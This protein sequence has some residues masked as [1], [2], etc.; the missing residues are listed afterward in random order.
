[1]KKNSIQNAHAGCISCIGHWL[2]TAVLLL[3]VILPSQLY[4]Q[5]VKGHTPKGQTFKGQTFKVT[6]IVKDSK[7]SPIEG[8]S[9]LVKGT[10]FGSTT[11]QQG[12][13]SIEAPSPKS[14]LEFTN[15]GYTPW[16]EDIN[17]RN[18]IA[19]TLTDKTSDMS[20]VVV[21]GYGTQRKRDITGAIS[22][23][24][25][26]QIAERQ[27]VTVA[28]ALQGQ[29][30][31]LQ[32]AVGSG[33]PGAS[34]ISSNQSLLIRGIG[35]LQTGAGPLVIIDGAQGVDINSINP[36]D[37]QSVEVLKDAASASIYGSK[38]AN[39]V[40]LIT[41]KRG[42]DGKPLLGVNYISSWSSLSHKIPQTNAAQRKL[43]DF[44]RT[45]NYSTSTDSLNP[46]TNA[47]ND[48]Q[49]MLTRT[50]RRD[51]LDM[52]VSSGTKNLNFYSG[53]SYLNEQGIIINSWSKTVRGRLNVDY[54][55]NKFSFGTRVVGSYNWSNFI[56]EGN[57]L[58]QA[59]QRPPNFAMVFPDG[60]LAPVI[61]GRKNPVAYALL[62]KNRYDIV[63]ASMY[64]YVAYQLTPDLKLTVDANVSIGP[65]HNLQFTPTLLEGSN[66]GKETNTVE[67]Y[68][69]TQA[70]L[71]FSKTLKG[72]HT[73]IGLLG[74]S[75]EEKYDK[76]SSQSGTSFVSEQVTSI[77]TAQVL[78]LPTNTETKSTQ[79]SVFGRVGYSY[80]GRYI[81]DGNL[82]A[83]ASSN[84]G[85]Q[86]R[87]GYFPSASAAWRFSD[88]KFMQFASG[89]LTD[90]KLRVSYGLT[91][92]QQIPAYANIS[93]LQFGNNYYNGVS[94]V[95]ASSQFGNNKLSWESTTQFNVGTD[96]NM[97][98]NRV[99][100]TLDYYN[101][102]TDNLLYNAPLAYETGFNTLYVNV[103]SLQNRG[104]E[105]IINATPVQTRN[106]TWNVSYNMSFNRAK[107]LSLYQNIPLS[108]SIWITQPN[109]T[110]GNFYGW[111]AKGIY[112]YDQSNAYDD[113]YNQL[114]PVI[115]NGQP[116]GQYTSSDGK[117]YT[118]TVHKLTTN[119]LVSAGGDVI[120]QNNHKDS[121]IDDNDRQVL[122]NAQPK[123]FAGL[124]N[125]VTYK[126]LSFSF[127]FYASMGGQLYNMFRS[128]L[129]QIVTTNVTPDP[130]YINQAWYYQ[131]QETNWYAANNNGKTNPRTS[132]LFIEDASFIRLRNVRLSY[133]IPQKISSKAGIKGIQLY[134][135]GI[136]VA[137]WTNYSGWDPEVSFSNPLQMGS[138]TGTYPKKKE[139]GVGVNVNF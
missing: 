38:S 133:Y 21:I 128:N 86:N 32:I 126:N 19:V 4:A 123:Y 46:S 98:N 15:V 88:E 109:Q 121:V 112:A 18:E 61:G 55:Q 48:Y 119:G 90:G 43:Y 58:A 106:F 63:N 56:S 85:A 24:S 79:A 72:K 59:I 74:T 37:I 94:G 114:T 120:W 29:V 92:N 80:L 110:L 137:T 22:S 83:D 39:G 132:S 118:G 71:N 36:N 64:N 14:T 33:A 62:Y 65:T 41:T 99:T 26:K 122:G 34:N 84:F 91:G 40:I 47:D 52:S 31:G 3:S 35:T 87:W 1:M 75:A 101:K 10:K 93:Q 134:V 111:K 2:L 73:I 13:Y 95:V 57:T 113:N 108:T 127:T 115:V 103:G 17:G 44:K 25:A 76:T 70:Y 9:V 81:I 89:F 54:K 124:T 28:D 49:D 116:S 97:L 130:A 125:T 102:R 96:L 23:V 105:F 100:L 107:T 67:N 42:S 66:S 51:E 45:G 135:Y 117:N 16:E 77:N 68:W 8:V 30:P 138:D 7:G 129:D 78:A 60:T 104:V 11:N 20:D 131:G 12:H 27:A 50:G 53:L 69:I 82:R 6:G 136:N 139:F 5:A